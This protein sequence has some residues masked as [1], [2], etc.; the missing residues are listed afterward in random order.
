MIP[1]S[2][3]ALR[4]A[5]LDRGFVYIGRCSLAEGVLTIEE[6]NCLRRWGTVAGLGQLAKRGRQPATVL[7]YTGLVRAPEHALI[8]LIECDEDAW[9]AAPVPADETV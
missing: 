2:T 5:V 7:D 9:A 4:I 6:A 8:H 1:I 3:P